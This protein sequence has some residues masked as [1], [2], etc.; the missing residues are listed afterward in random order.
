MIDAS[1]DKVLCSTIICCV[2]I[3]PMKKMMLDPTRECVTKRANGIITVISTGWR[4]RCNIVAKTVDSTEKIH[5][6]LYERNGAGPGALH[7]GSLLRRR[8]RGRR[9]R[10]STKVLYNGR[11]D[12][13]GTNCDYETQIKY[14]PFYTVT[15]VF[16]GKL[17]RAD[18]GDHRHRGGSSKILRKGNNP[19]VVFA[20]RGMRTDKKKTIALKQNRNRPIKLQARMTQTGGRPFLGV[21]FFGLCGFFHG[22][23]FGARIC[24]TA[25][26]DHIHPDQPP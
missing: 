11:S 22:S 9:S 8:T 16:T 13:N 3:C 21:G 20:A 6:V 14:N 7:N 19:T 25:G 10:L 12:L 17:G 15:D 23:A 26:H 24:M 18:L 4:M 2:L 5:T 1:N